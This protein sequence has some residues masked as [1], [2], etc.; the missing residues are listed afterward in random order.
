MIILKLICS[1][2]NRSATESYDL[3]WIYP[4]IPRVGDYFA[5]YSFIKDTLRDDV[6][7]FDQNWNGSTNFIVDSVQF[8][9]KQKDQNLYIEIKMTSIW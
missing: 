6:E 1:N 3:Y 7:P 4:L 8:M 2:S 9:K 5:P